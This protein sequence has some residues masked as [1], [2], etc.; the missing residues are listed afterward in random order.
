MLDINHDDES[1]ERLER[2]TYSQLPHN[3]DWRLQ[4]EHEEQIK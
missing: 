4:D 1:L 3:S 2:S